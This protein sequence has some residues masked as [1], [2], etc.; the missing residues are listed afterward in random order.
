RNLSRSEVESP[1]NKNG[2]PERAAWPLQHGTGSKPGGDPMSIYP[3]VD[4]CRDCLH[5]AGWSISEAGGGLGWI[6]SN[7]NGVHQI[8]AEGRTQAEAWR[9]TA[10]QAQCVLGGHALTRGE[11]RSFLRVPG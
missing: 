2:P 11:A 9:Q 10:L 7:T 4:E 5:R 3:N 1:M 6:V 8:K